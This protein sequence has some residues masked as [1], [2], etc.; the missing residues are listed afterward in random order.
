MRGETDSQVR[1]GA[2]IL[3]LP[4]A[5]LSGIDD[6]SLVRAT[7]NG[8]PRAP[9]ALWEKHARLVYR[10]LRRSLGQQDEVDDLVQ[11]VFLSLFRKLPTLREP[12]ALPA[13]LIAI[14]THVL[15]H[16]LRRR[17][18]RRC[19]TLGAK[20]DIG[21]DPR[22][23]YPNPEARQAVSRLYGIL[24]KLGSEER[25][26]FV[27]RFIEGMELTEVATALGLSLATAK[28]RLVR[29]RARFD[30][31]VAGDPGLAPYLSGIDKES[32]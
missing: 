3:T 31:H 12:K 16:E 15:R 11:E 28:R 8:D 18:V 24:D 6:A 27:L 20:A 5:N 10:I 7:L 17:W 22:V 9:S 23:V 32:P 25:L 2:K 26:A 14:T 21:P 13:F 1:E 4:T 19:M 29:A 30:R